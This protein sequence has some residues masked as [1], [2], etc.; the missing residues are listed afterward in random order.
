MDDCPRAYF[1]HYYASHS[2]WLDEA[3]P[4]SKKAYRLYQL[5]SIDIILD[6]EMDERAFET[7]V[8]DEGS[9]LDGVCTQNSD[10]AALSTRLTQEN[11]VTTMT[12]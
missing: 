6:Q 12:Q 11:E 1:Y 9:A 10:L 2:G 7:T 8:L 4:P 5:A 3:G